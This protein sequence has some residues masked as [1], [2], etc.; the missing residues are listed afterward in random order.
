MKQILTIIVILFS[1]QTQAQFNETVRTGRP[2][3]AIGPFAVGKFVFQTQTGFDVVGFDEKQNNFSSYNIAPNTVL[4]FGLTRTFEINTAWEYRNDNY[5]ISDSS[6]STNGL[7]SAIIGT[8]INLFEGKNYIP[9]LGLQ[10][11]FKLPNLSQP[12][13]SKYI[14]PKIMLIANEKINDKIS[15]LINFRNEL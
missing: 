13:N 1:Q 3:Q 5:K 7:S 8:R 2:G 6:F 4:R 14:A 11:G 15:F 10:V 9:S 12:Y